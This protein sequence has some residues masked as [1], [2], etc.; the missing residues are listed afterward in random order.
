MTTME[1]EAE[2]PEIPA[3]ETP[4]PTIRRRGEIPP[5]VSTRVAEVVNK[6]VANA[7]SIA[8]NAKAATQT[9]QPKRGP[10]RPPGSKN[11]TTRTPAEKTPRTPTTPLSAQ[12]VKESLSD[13]RTSPKDKVDP[14]DF[15][16]WRDF[17]GE[18]VLHWFSVA[19]IAVMFRGIPYHEIMSQEDYEDI[20]LDEDEL[21]AVARPFAHLLAHSKINGKYGRAIMNSRDSIEAT[22]VL[23]MWF[24]RANRISKKY[25]NSYRRYVEEQQRI[26]EGTPNVVTRIDR[27]DRQRDSTEEAIVPQAP[28]GLHQ[29]AF[30]HGFN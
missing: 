8:P 11:K 13:S 20:Q 4:V 7:S 29:P 21:T 28:I 30:G 16:E 17:L 6:A 15:T 5:E 22:V 27:P 1:A 3:E 19:A 10:G 25:R 14:P 26:A 12:A 23:F 9:N 2:L 24:Q 18:V